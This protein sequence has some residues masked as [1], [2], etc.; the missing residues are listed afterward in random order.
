MPGPPLCLLCREESARRDAEAL[1]GRTINDVQLLAISRASKMHIRLHG[2]LAGDATAHYAAFARHVLFMGRVLCVDPSHRD[3]LGPSV[4][5]SL[6]SRMLAFLFSPPPLPSQIRSHCRCP[7][8]HTRSRSCDV[9]TVRITSAANAKRF[10]RASY[11]A[12]WQLILIS[13]ANTDSRAPVKCIVRV[14]SSYGSHVYVFFTRETV[15]RI[16]EKRLRSASERKSI[17]HEERREIP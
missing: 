14:F 10:A 11:S 12:A 2:K 17:S 6:L 4:S 16:M 13:R 1:A 5:R 3:I 8:K 15:T 9:T 7:A